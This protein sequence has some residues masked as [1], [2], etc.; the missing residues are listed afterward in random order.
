MKDSVINIYQIFTRLF[1]NANETNKEFGS[2]RENGCSKFSNVTSLALSEI[3]KMGVTHVWYTGV[4]RHASCTSYAMNGLSADNPQVVKGQAGSPYAIKDYYDVDPDLATNVK[5]RMKEFEA[6]LDRTHKAG[7]KAI[8]DFVPNHVSREYHSDNLPSGCIDLGSHDQ[9]DK[10]FSPNN[11]FYYVPGEELHLPENISFP[12]NEKAPVYREYPAKVTGNDV[13]SA[14]PSRNDWYETVKLNYGV[15]YQDCWR[16]HFDQVPDTWLRMLEIL[17]FWAKK[18]IDGFRCDMA[19]M[20]PVEFWGWVIPQIK[21]IKPSIIFI[22]EIYNPDAYLTYLNTGHFD[23][24]YDKV[25]LYDTVRM[26]VEGNGSARNISDYW[27]RT[28]GLEGK[29]LRFLENH[30]EQRIASRFFAGNAEKA[31]AAMILLATLNPGPLMIYFGQEIGESGMYK[32]GFSGVDGRTT[33]FDYWALPKFN[34]WV[35]DGKFDGGGLSQD[36]KDL[37]DFYSRLLN[38]RLNS[39]TV[40]SGAFYDLMW[41]NERGNLNADKIFAYLRYTEKEKLLFVLNF[42]FEHTHSFRLHIGEHA[43]QTMGS[44]LEGTLYIS[45]LFEKD[46]VDNFSMDE[47]LR[48][49]LPISIL[50]NSALIFRLEWR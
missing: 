50:P 41:K 13:F 49:G 1:A 38:F 3:K 2:I 6:M 32:E 18:D 26:I 42:D 8:I 30:D 40:Q 48:N 44:P 27:K 24:L 45:E 20:V 12:Y 10:A 36:Q 28:G 9:T 35:N 4:I 34:K 11:N 47:V 5:S 46:F 19:E 23:Y 39:K 17:T 16:K 37:R 43:F 29:M 15:D 31:R 33:I 14:Y 7:L 25:G 22:A 21:K